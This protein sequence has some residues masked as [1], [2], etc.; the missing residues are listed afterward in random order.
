MAT[1]SAFGAAHVTTGIATAGVIA[2]DSD[3]AGG[4]VATATLDT[5]GGTVIIHGLVSV[6][7]GGGNLELTNGL[8]IAAHDIVT[9]SSLT[10][11]AIPS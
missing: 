1:P 8:T 3:A 6:P 11:Q 5:S 10:Y 4:T 2:Q 7:A 9:C